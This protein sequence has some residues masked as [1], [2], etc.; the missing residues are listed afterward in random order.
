MF[1]DVEGFVA[2]AK[3]LGPARTVEVLNIIMRAFDQLADRWGVEKIKTIG[4]SY[5]AAAGLPVPA[6]DHAERLAG[7]SLAMLETARRIAREVDVPFALRIGIASG[8]VLAGVIGAKRLIYDVWG[9]TVNLAS[10]L[11]GQSEANRILVSPLTCERLNGRYA[12]ESRGPV[13]IKGYGAVEAFFLIAP[14]G[15]GGT[16]LDDAGGSPAQVVPS[17]E[18]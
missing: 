8:P 16:R 17:V 6:P 13:D 5:M 12:L 14:L 10:R 9:D 7:M 3:R 1:A 2:H 15:E 4:D 11:E 18:R